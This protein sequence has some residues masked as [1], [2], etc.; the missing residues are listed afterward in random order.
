M[1]LVEAIDESEWNSLVA[2]KKKEWIT[3]ATQQFVVEAS[4][5]AIKWQDKVENFQEV[6]KRSLELVP[7][8][9]HLFE[10]AKE[11]TNQVGSGSNL[12]TKDKVKQ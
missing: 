7:K 10:E 1:H 8:L 11:E 2:S 4:L 12:E 9:G 6:G 3:D 5:L